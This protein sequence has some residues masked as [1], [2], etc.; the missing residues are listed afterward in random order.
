MESL[1]ITTAVITLTKCC[2]TT[3]IDLYH[4][5]ERYQDA[6]N[7]IADLVEETQVLSTSLARVQK[8]LYEDSSAVFRAGIEDIFTIAIKGCRAT[9]LCLE[10]EFGDLKERSDWRM[11]I[12]TLWKEDTM[13]QLLDQLGRKKTSIML[14]VQCL[15]MDSINEVRIL[16]QANRPVLKQAKDDISS[17]IETYPRITVPLMES[18][19]RGTIASLTGS[20]DTTISTTEF[21]FDEEIVNTRVYRET[22]A[23][24]AGKGKRP[25][26]KTTQSQVDVSSD[27][28]GS[29]VT[30]TAQVSEENLIDPTEDT[31][32]T[33]PR[34]TKN[35]AVCGERTRPSNERQDEKFEWDTQDYNAPK[36]ERKLKLNR[37][38]TFPKI[39]R[40]PNAIASDP[41]ERP[42]SAAASQ[43]SLTN[44]DLEGLEWPP[45]NLASVVGGSGSAA[46]NSSIPVGYQ[47]V[48]RD[49]LNT[50][51]IVSTSL[52]DEGNQRVS[53]KDLIALMNHLTVRDEQRT[54]RDADILN[55]MARSTQNMRYFLGAQSQLGAQMKA[56]VPIVDEAAKEEQ[57]KGN[58]MFK[59]ALKGVVTRQPTA[60]LAQ[61]EDKLTQFV[62]EV[63]WLKAQ[64][65][66]QGNDCASPVAGVADSRLKALPPTPT[67]APKLQPDD[68][69][70]EFLS[71][72]LVDLS[73]SDTYTRL[74]I[75]EDSRALGRSVSDQSPHSTGPRNALE[76]SQGFS[77]SAMPSTMRDAT[78][79]PRKPIAMY[80]PRPGLPAGI[81]T[82]REIMNAR[83]ERE[84]RAER[85]RSGLP[86]GI[87][88]PIPQW[89]SRRPSSEDPINSRSMT[90]PRLR[91]SLERK[92]FYQEFDQHNDAL[93]HRG[94]SQERKQ[95]NYTIDLLKA[96]TRRISRNVG[97]TQITQAVTQ[98]PQRDAVRL[99]PPSDPI[100]RRK[101]P[102]EHSSEQK[103]P[104]S[105]HSPLS[106]LPTFDTELAKPSTPKSPTGEITRKLSAFHS[107]QRERRHSSAKRRSNCD[108][109]SDSN[110]ATV[111]PRS[112]MRTSAVDNPKL[113][114]TVGDAIKRLILP[115][116]T[117]LKEEQA[118]ESRREIF[119][120]VTAKR[121]KTLDSGPEEPPKRLTKILAAPI[122]PEIVLNRSDVELNLIY[123]DDLAS[124]IGKNTIPRN[125]VRLSLPSSRFYKITNEERSDFED[126][127]DDVPQ[128]N[129]DRESDAKERREEKQS[130]N[131]DGIVA[132]RLTVAALKRHDAQLRVDTA[133]RRK[134]YK[135]SKNI[136]KT[137]RRNR[138]TR[139]SKG[140]GETH[141][142]ENIP[143]LP[144]ELYFTA[145]EAT[146]ESIP[147]AKQEDSPQYPSKEPLA[148]PNLSQQTRAG[149]ASAACDNPDFC[150]ETD[151][152][153]MTDSIDN[154]KHSP[155]HS[156]IPPLPTTKTTIVGHTDTY[157]PTR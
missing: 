40:W 35:T 122:L 133:E 106:N 101:G 142:E 97:G 114:Q 135:N 109:G 50:P 91:R 70:R 140:N 95:T 120:K 36:R 19:D 34:A 81:R 27:S 99:K 72:S 41:R 105:T 138:N 33:T 148:L 16:L 25:S 46:H 96:P 22:L 127:T 10:E 132:A 32:T 88:P 152:N 145:P 48:P 119:K 79:S 117:A 54:A 98:K 139:A 44:P 153:A 83:R 42:C 89:D 110:G 1:S 134:R 103:V 92:T 28:E 115:E 23:R 154:V 111:Q 75:R 14:L 129:A 56:D 131:Q 90:S 112:L 67:I 107:D 8:A 64:R 141:H 150:F 146:R 147:G 151:S 155:S 85:D 157:A 94:R 45:D 43:T 116:L 78:S 102:T 113:L 37:S 5:F 63:E 144:K 71:A 77:S 65:K 21:T 130:E 62:G 73:P 136:S 12:A 30:K 61:L 118:A 86:R 66:M 125:G 47:A 59:R 49:Y 38:S 20:R 124:N 137:T 24:L 121:T 26:R 82:P 108:S 69:C 51:E 13:K 60:P 84:R 52:Q 2:T 6:P 11:R 93:P 55:S 31:S 156:I 149:V 39:S 3:A 123:P 18:L 74:K 104:P 87:V 68:G 9:L 4:A 57:S 76:P 126:G 29:R 17:L 7:T 128:T 80:V 53:S 100:D 58:N 15:H 143:P